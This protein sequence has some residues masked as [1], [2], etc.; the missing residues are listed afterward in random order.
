MKSLSSWLIALLSCLEAAPAIA[1]NVTYSFQGSF[2]D[3]GSISGTFVYDPVA[4]SYAV[5]SFTYAGVVGEFEYTIS[6]VTSGIPNG[7]Y[8]EYFGTTEGASDTSSTPTQFAVYGSM[9]GDP[10]IGTS[11]SLVLNW[12][13]ALNGPDGNMLQPITGGY[14][15]FEQCNGSCVTYTSYLSGSVG[16]VPL[17]PG[18]LLLLS[19]LGGLCWFRHRRNSEGAT[20]RTAHAS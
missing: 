16:P 10:F 5:G 12:N 20:D 3:N 4:N 8:T 2:I 11:W 9:G 17:P 13:N 18:G 7:E 6:G 1:S 14:A 15:T 19:G